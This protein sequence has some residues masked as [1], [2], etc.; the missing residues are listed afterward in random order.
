MGFPPL[1]HPTHLM[2]RYGADY[3]NSLNRWCVTGRAITTLARQKIMGFPPLT[4]PTGY[5]FISYLLFEPVVRYGAGY[6]NPG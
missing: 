3:S 2:V 1:T 5:G 4:H 6:H